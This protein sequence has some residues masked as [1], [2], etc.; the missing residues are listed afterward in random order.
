MPD[1]PI[2]IS[3]NTYNNGWVKPEGYDWS[4]SLADIN[5]RNKATLIVKE[6]IGYLNSI[7]YKKRLISLGEKNP[8]SLIKNR[9]NSLMS[10]QFFGGQE[11][12]SVTNKSLNGANVQI[13]SGA[14]KDVISHEIGHVTS[15]LSKFSNSASE[16]KADSMSPIE[17]WKFINADKNITS[18]QKKD[19]YKWYSSDAKQF[20]QYMTDPSERIL[21][22]MDPHMVGAGEAKADIDAMRYLL[23]QNGIT[24]KYGEDI[25]SDK[26]KKALDN[27]EINSNK[28]IKRL[29]ERYSDDAIIMLNNTVA[30]NSKED[31]SNIV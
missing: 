11:G 12:S 21:S 26:L 3:G 23:N 18:A 6:K 2:K 15:G 29:R 28:F 9:I 22:D 7:E 13:A 25:D 20:G 17:A 4:P 10:I 14:G 8:D 19:I 30:S 31:E 27:K 16:G 5:A 1:N 24:E